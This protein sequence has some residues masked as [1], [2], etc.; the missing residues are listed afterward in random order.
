LFASDVVVL[1]ALPV[2]TS[3][4]QLPAIPFHYNATIC[5]AEKTHLRGCNTPQYTTEFACVQTPVPFILSL[6][7]IPLK[8][9]PSLRATVSRSSTKNDIARLIT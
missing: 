7:N 6:S 1:T 8:C 2:I 3:S 4:I 9:P 5:S